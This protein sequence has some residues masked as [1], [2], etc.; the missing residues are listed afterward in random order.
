VLVNAGDK[1]AK[2]L[3]Q[4]AKAANF[5]FPGGMGPPK[6]V[7]AKRKE[8]LRFCLSTGRATTC[9]VEKIT[10][11]KGR[12]CPPVC[13]AC[14]LVANELREAWFRRWPEMERYFDRISI[15]T[16]G[17]FG[18]EITSYGNGM[19]RGACGFCDGA[20]HRFQNLAAQGA[21]RAMYVVTREC[22]TNRKSPL[23]GSHPAAFIHDELIAELVESRAHEAAERMAEIMRT[24]MRRYTPDVR[25]DAEPCLMRHWYK[26]AKTIRDENGRLLVWEPA[27]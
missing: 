18:G 20:N 4:A 1:R 25:I 19:I 9:G 21:K 2:G 13:K 8:G 24:E 26:D 16:S 3:R 23:W 14:V 15:E 6:L 17:E 12:P 7:L 27:A 10:E 22:L 5:G 11:W